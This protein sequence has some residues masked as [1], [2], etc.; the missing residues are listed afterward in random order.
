M[1]Y[2]R[3]RT[4]PRLHNAMHLLA[5]QVPV[6]VVAHRCGWAT[7]SAFIEVYRRTLGY[8]PGAFRT[9]QDSK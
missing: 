6:T 3:W 8:T 7:A 1:T 2:P 5:E 9:N 4:Q